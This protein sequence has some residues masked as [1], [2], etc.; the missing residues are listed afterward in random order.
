MLLKIVSA[1]SSHP[2]SHGGRRIPLRPL[3]PL[4]PL[5]PLSASPP[6][7]CSRHLSLFTFHVSLARSAPYPLH[8]NL[9]QMRFPSLNRCLDRSTNFSV[10]T[11]HRRLH[12]H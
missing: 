10:R 2:P 9:D 6:K 12:P 11:H 3:S 7:T 5:R 4:G 1:Q 8:R